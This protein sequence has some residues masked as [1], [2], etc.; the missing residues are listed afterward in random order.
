MDEISD[1]LIDFIISQLKQEGDFDKLLYQYMITNGNL[2]WKQVCLLLFDQDI[3]DKNDDY[4]ALKNDQINAYDFM[5]KKIRNIEITP[6]MLAL[7]PCSG[8]III[9]DPAN[10][11][12]KALVSY[13]SYDNNKLANGID[14]GYYSKLVNDQSSPMLNRCTQTRTAPGS[15]FK[16]IISTAVLEDGVVDSGDTI[17]CTGVFDKI[18]P[19]AKC[20]IYPN[21]HGRLN[22]SGAIAVSCNFF[23]YEMGYRLGSKNGSYNSQRGLK[24]IARYASLYG[25]DRKSGVEISEYEPHI[26]DEDAVRSAIGQGT[27]NYTP[28]Q[29]S[30]F[31]TSLV[32]EDNLLNLTLLDKSTDSEGNVL[33]EYDKEAEDKLNVKD[34]TFGQIKRGMQDVVYGKNS[35]IKFLYQK[36]GLKV[37]GKT[38][39]AQENKNRPNHALFISYAPFDS[40]E[41]TMTVVVPNGYTSSNAAEIAR[42]IY[43]YYFKKTTEEEEKNKQ[44]LIPSQNDSSTTD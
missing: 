37:A 29:I 8:S 1:A 42:D 38:G 27:H 39:T 21:A 40:P 36:L 23:F 2:K 22:V 31:V 34:G 6:A 18:N 10:G 20:W 17:K 35:S 15:T 12:V 33:E 13:P 19:S 3:L 30:R 5:S 16:P 9:T 26:S 14:S 32:N 25:L 4:E 43:K 7:D 28:V 11:D 44:A 41:I 24:R